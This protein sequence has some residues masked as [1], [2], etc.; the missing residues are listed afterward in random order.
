MAISPESHVRVQA[1]W[2]EH[3]TKLRLQD[4]QP[5]QQRD[6]AGRPGRLHA[7]LGDWVQGGDRIPG[8]LQV[9]AGAG[10]GVRGGGD[11][12]R[13][14]GPPGAP[15]AARLGHRCHR[16]G[17]NGSRQ[18][19]RH[20][21]LRRIGPPLRAVH[22]PWEGRGV[23][24]GQ[25]GGHLQA[26]VAGAAV[27]HRSEP[28]SGGPTGHHVLPGLG[29]RHAGEVRAGRRGAG[30]GEPPAVRGPVGRPP[31]MGRRRPGRRPSSACSPRR[32]PPAAS[33]TIFP[34][35]PD[36]LSA[37]ATSS[38]RRGACAAW[39]AATPSASRRRPRNSAIIG[40]R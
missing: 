18:H 14:P 16:Q 22:D 33:G 11:R 20:G 34:A 5:G 28:D 4:D 10:D 1:K 26:G 38:T 12:L 37:P 6:G 23:R 39:T 8:R 40:L 35:P 32:G 31:R 13:E 17:A 29:L 9:D 24:L 36:A 19:V 2:Q 27:R 3:V 15:A 7:G 21:E 30:S 25:P